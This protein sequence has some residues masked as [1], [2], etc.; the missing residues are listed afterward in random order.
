MC[1]V[2]R[3]KNEARV[4]RHISVA[5]RGAKYLKILIESTNEAWSNSVSIIPT[6]PQ[7]DYSVGF[8]Q[9]EFIED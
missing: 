5:K 4:V 2:I 6:F 1:K 3:D 7:P 8:G 9:T